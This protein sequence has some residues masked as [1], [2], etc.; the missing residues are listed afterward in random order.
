MELFAGEEEASPRSS[1]AGNGTNSQENCPHGR[2]ASTESISGGK[3]PGRPVLT[4]E[5]ADRM[6]RKPDVNKRMGNIRS[7]WRE[8]SHRQSGSRNV[9]RRGRTRSDKPKSSDRR[10]QRRRPPAR[11]NR[12]PSR[13]EFANR[14]ASND[15]T[16]HP[17]ET[18]VEGMAARLP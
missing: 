11:G 7:Q 4:K 10:R 16:D 1:V 2:N 17:V 18:S 13:I 6:R 9:P 15:H 3:S 8:P 14:G 5:R 12:P